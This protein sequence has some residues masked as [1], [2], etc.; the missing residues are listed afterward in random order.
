MK[1]LLQMLRDNARGERMPVNL[2]RADADGD[3]DPPE[4][5]LYVYDVIDAYWGINAQDVAKAVA[6]LDPSTTLHVRFNS[7]GG[8][9]FEG[10]AIAQAIKQFQG[11]TIGHID[12][13]A[14]SAATTV[15]LACDELEIAEGAFFMI[16]NSWTFT[17][18]DKND[19]TETADLLGKIDMAIAADY[20]ACTGKPNDQVVAWM[21]AETWFSA[22]EAVDNGF[23]D[24]LMPAPDKT[25]KGAENRALARTW[26]LA[27]FAHA[28]KAL[29]EPPPAPAPD[30][31]EQLKAAADNRRRRLQL[32]ALA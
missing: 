6:A 10:R 32:L 27:A 30:V 18:G 7:P 16:H 25:G 11:K 19:L 28:P 20:S 26:N 4:V 9:V 1:K 14:A 5:T 8:D 24:R 13:L 29:T 22:Q 12:A 31:D 2:V 23:C 15:A 21:D 3:Q 17:Y